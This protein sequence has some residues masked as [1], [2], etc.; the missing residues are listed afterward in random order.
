MLIGYKDDLDKRLVQ[1]YSDTGAVHIIAIS[2]LHLGLIYWLL[3]LLCKPLAK[4]KT[5]KII[6]PILVI[7]GL[8]AFSFIAG[9]SPSVLR[10]AV[11]FTC[12]VLGNHMNRKASVYNSL[13]A[14]AFLLLCY[15]PFWLWDAGFQLS[16]AAVLSLAIFYKP[17]YDL[18]FFPQKMID[19]VWKSVCVTLAA[20][21]LTVPVSIYH[22][23]QFPN[24][25]LFANLLAVPLSSL[26]IFGEIAI[27]ITSIFPAIA[28]GTGYLVH[29]LI[30][31]LN[32]FIELVSS[33]PFAITNDLQINL[34]Q[35]VCLYAFIAAIAWWLFRNKKLGVSIALVAI[36]TFTVF[37]ITSVWTALHQKKLIVYNIPRHSAIDV[38]V[39]KEYL[40][41][42]DSLLQHDDLL[43]K[44]HLQPSRSLHR[45]NNANTT[46][47]LRSENNR[48][49]LGNFSFLLIDQPYNLYNDTPKTPV[50][51]III[52]NNPPLK[53]AQLTSVFTCR[54]FIFDASNA[55]WKVAKWQQECDQLGLSG[56]S[57]ADKGAFVLNLY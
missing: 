54:Q 23:H 2:G 18:F 8:W 31:G 10:S 50:D 20:Q 38:M 25:F 41:K 3:M 7:T 33:L 27:C 32:N 48:F 56:F 4:Y 43:Q 47:I 16:Y 36:L 6:Q 37:H 49:K 39:G 52:L 51:I 30:Y 55:P 57:V 14:S 34:A 42:G 17:V 45:V 40:F 12:L 21:I 26:V 44:F 46:G 9:G 29:F 11:M 35:L 5:G 22:F 13:A 53:I 15:N 28:G 1:S 19:I 24:L